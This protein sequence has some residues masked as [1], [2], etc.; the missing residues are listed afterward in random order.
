MSVQGKTLNMVPVKV[1][2]T[3]ND[4]ILLMSGGDERFAQISD[5][6]SGVDD[7]NSPRVRKG[8]CEASRIPTKFL[9]L[10]IANRGRAS[11][12]VKFDFHGSLP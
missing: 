4:F 7:G 2:E 5:S 6:G 9:K 11:G 8:D 3:D 12:S 1:S 10:G